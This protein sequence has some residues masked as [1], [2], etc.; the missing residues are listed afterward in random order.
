MLLLGNPL[1]RTT[2]AGAQP[3]DPEP[4]PEPEVVAQQPRGHAGPF[5]TGRPRSREDISRDR[6][7]FGVIDDIA[8]AAIAEVAARQVERGETDEQKRFDELYRELALRRIEFDARY[9]ELLGALRQQL[10]E[11][12]IARQRRDEEEI[13]LLLMLASQL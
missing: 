6:Q 8:A 10:V 2:G 7:R 1:W 12:A 4:E 3:P 13:L 5:L 11:Q 9:L